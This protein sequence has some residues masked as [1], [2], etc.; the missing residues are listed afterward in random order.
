VLARGLGQGAVL[1]GMSQVVLMSILG[2][3]VFGERLNAH[4]IVGLGLAVCS[5]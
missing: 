5:I 3:L 1:S 4:Q 2:T